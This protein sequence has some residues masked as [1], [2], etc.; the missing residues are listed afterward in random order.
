MNAIVPESYC[1]FLFGQEADQVFQLSYLPERLD[2]RQFF[3]RCLE[4]A[5]RVNVY[6]FTHRDAILLLDPRAYNKQCQLYALRVCQIHR[7]YSQKTEEEKMAFTEENRFLHLAF[8]LNY[9]F[10]ESQTYVQTVLSTMQMMGLDPFHKE[11]ILK[12]FKIFLKDGDL[13][14]EKASRLAFNQIF[15][16][17]TKESLHQL[18]DQGPLQKELSLLADEDLQIDGTSLGVRIERLYTYPKLAGLAYLIDAMVQERLHFVI[19]VK[20][21]NKNGYGG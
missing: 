16:K 20:V 8:F 2:K 11:F 21:V 19:K 7:R 10:R 6:L 5:I 17:Q 12:R 14:R 3:E 4:L 18:R 9:Q 13:N 1:H 15:E